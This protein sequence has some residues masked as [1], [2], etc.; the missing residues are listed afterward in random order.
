MKV[1]LLIQFLS[2]EQFILP[3]FDL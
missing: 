2:P 1:V 3:E